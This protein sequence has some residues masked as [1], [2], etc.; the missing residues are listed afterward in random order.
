MP[1]AIE[2]RSERPAD[3]AAVEEIH[4][5]AFDRDAE[6]Q[7]VAALRDLPD[8]DPAVSLLASQGGVIRGHI[9]FTKLSIERDGAILDSRETGEVYGL[10]PVAVAPEWQRQSIGS[11]LV[12][13]GLDACRRRGGCFVIV[14]GHPDYY[15]RFGFTSA[16]A[17]G[18]EAPFP[19][20]DAAF[21][22]CDLLAKADERSAPELRGR[23]QYPAPF[24]AV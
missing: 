18:L 3:Y 2:I 17:A 11:A 8:F 9:L 22:V 16:R 5:Q 6:A 7:L 13:A 19:V 24:R 14:V 15:P 10:A 1:D 4:R 20:S 12:R 23:V 21:M